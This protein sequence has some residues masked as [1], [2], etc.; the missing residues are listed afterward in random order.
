MA[1]DLTPNEAIVLCELLNGSFPE[2]LTATSLEV[3]LNELPNAD[4]IYQKWG[5]NTIFLAYKIRHASLTDIRAL[6]AALMSFWGYADIS[7]EEALE[8]SGML[9]I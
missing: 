9:G 4:A 1:L 7:R 5:L 6:R 2:D 8:R 3:E